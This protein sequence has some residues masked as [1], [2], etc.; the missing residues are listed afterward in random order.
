MVYGVQKRLH[1]W[2]LER[3][4]RG[5][6]LWLYHLLDWHHRPILLP[7]RD[8]VCVSSVSGGGLLLL[9]VGIVECPWQVDSTRWSPSTRLLVPPTF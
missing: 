1:L 5:A 6:C 7:C 8:G 9:M 4:A 3:R 2:F